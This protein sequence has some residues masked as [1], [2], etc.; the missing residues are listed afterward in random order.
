MGFY[1]VLPEVPSMGQLLA[2]NLGQGVSQGIGKASDLASQ[3]MMEKSKE[4]QKNKWAQELVGSLYGN[5]D[6]GSS[7][8]PESSSESSSSSRERPKI[9]DLPDENI[10]AL[11]LNRETAPLA[12]ILQKQKKEAKSEYETRIASQDAFDDMVNLTSKIGFSLISDPNYSV[13]KKRERSQFEA[14]KGA[15]IGQLKD[16]VN[17]GV[18]SNQKFNFIKDELL[19]SHKD[20]REVKIG[21]LKAVGKELGVDTSQLD[22]L[23]PDVGDWKGDQKKPSKNMVKMR[24][25]D[26]SE[27]LVPK[28][29]V[30]D[31]MKAGAWV[32]K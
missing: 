10:A 12:T 24:A 18:L 31:A 13:S 4:S 5:N 1:G 28:D 20:S 15:L 3:L 21:K 22:E 26:G 6:A 27:E 29:K 19:P 25:P 23:Y 2:R 32:V 9:L 16:R 11:S 14:S 17:K 8:S 7:A 30:K